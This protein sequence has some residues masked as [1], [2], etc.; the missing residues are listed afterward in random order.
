M[1]HCLKA[2]TLSVG[3]TQITHEINVK[4]TTLSIGAV[5]R[6][7]YYLDLTLQ[8]QYKGQSKKP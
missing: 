1:K 7:E 3:Q 6:R 8:T 2:S 5:S 4:N